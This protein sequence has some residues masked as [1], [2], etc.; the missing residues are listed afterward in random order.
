MPAWVPNDERSP[1]R[2]KRSRAITQGFFRILAT[3]RSASAPGMR[4]MK[5]LPTRLADGPLIKIL[6]HSARGA[7]S[8]IKALKGSGAFPITEPNGPSH[9]IMLF[10]SVPVGTMTGAQSKNTV[11]IDKHRKNVDQSVAGSRLTVNSTSQ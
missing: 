3:L 1:K 10:I 2:A 9:R 4:P 5:L 6:I 11:P 8:I 7:S